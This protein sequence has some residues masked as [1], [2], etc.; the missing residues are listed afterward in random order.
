[1]QVSLFRALRS[2]NIAEDTAE[3][4]VHAIEEHIDMAVTEAM[5]HYDDRITNMQTV[6]EAKLDS[7]LKNIELGIKG[8]EGKLTGFEGK[9]A[10]SDGKID[11]FQGQLKAMQGT[12]D[13]IKWV[14]IIQT[15]VLTSVGVLFGAIKA[16]L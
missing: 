13:M 14:V 10:G 11:G 2:A 6:L 5:K 4:V 9:L 3:Q 15:G 1:M 12:I 16:F 7:G 8:F